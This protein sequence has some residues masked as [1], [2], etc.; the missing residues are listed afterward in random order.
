MGISSL[1]VIMK[2][3]W[4]IWDTGVF[5]RI[6]VVFRKKILTPLL[7]STTVYWSLL[8]CWSLLTLINT[9][10][11]RWRS[12]NDV[13]KPEQCAGFFEDWGSW[14]LQVS[15]VRENGPYRPSCCHPL[16]P[17]QG[18]I[19]GGPQGHVGNIFCNMVKRAMLNSNMWTEMTAWCL[20][21]SSFHTVLRCNQLFKSKIP[22]K[23]FFA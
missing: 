4:T 7:L 13:A 11:H 8:T 9:F 12:V 14:K 19:G 22:L 23:F 5:D 20:M 2:N 10:E 3:V 21:L 17:S 18:L 16:P 1:W 6:N 15:T